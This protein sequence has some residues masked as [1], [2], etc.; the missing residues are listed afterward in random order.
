LAI[1]TA[2]DKVEA[3]IGLAEDVQ[4]VHHSAIWGQ[5]LR[6]H[7]V[8]MQDGI[9][10]PIKARLIALGFV[11]ETFVHYVKLIDDRLTDLYLVILIKHSLPGRL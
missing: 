6:S 8:A 9:N 4:R 1:S 2:G 7:I 11:S 10:D 5:V 3:N